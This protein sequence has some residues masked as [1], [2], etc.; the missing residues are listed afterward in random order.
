MQISS[1]M[2][3]PSKSTGVYE[4]WFNIRLVTNDTKTIWMNKGKESTSLY[5]CIYTYMYTQQI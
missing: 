1:K 5:K 3:H 4:S 2:G